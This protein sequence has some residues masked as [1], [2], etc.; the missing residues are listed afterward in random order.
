MVSNPDHPPPHSYQHTNAAP[1][2]LSLEGKKLNWSGIHNLALLLFLTNL[3]RLIVVNGKMHGFIVRYPSSFLN[4]NDF[5]AF[6]AIF[7]IFSF[8]SFVSYFLSSYGLI[9]WFSYITLLVG[10]GVIIFKNVGGTSILLSSI[11]LCCSLILFMKLFSY[12]SSKDER[13]SFGSFLRFLFLPTLCY[14]KKYPSNAGQRI[15]FRMILK[16]LIEIMGCLGMIHVLVEQYSIPTIM[17]SHHILEDLW[18]DPFSLFEHVVLLGWSSLL[19]WFLSF[20][21]I[22]HCWFNL[23][24]EILDF[25]DRQSFYKDWWNAPGINEYWQMWNGPMHQWFKRHVYHPL[26]NKYNFS[27]LQCQL[28]IF[29]ISALAHEYL[30]SVPL[31]TWEGWS[32]FA[33]FFQVPL[34]K[35][36]SVLRKKFPESK[37]LG[38]YI[39]WVIFCI[40]GQPACILL[41]YRAWYLRNK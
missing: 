14:Q 37:S 19:V 10:P 8:S 20:Y 34:I 1:S 11:M 39:F 22:F 29:V 7:A 33:M 4:F 3:L 25:G 16:Y 27:H 12:D 6:M 32:F 36:T 13:I 21:I 35:M 40:I 9:K 41:Y 2:P 5:G 18:S 15:S 24:G 28:V 17:G 26:I 38:N 30:I 23:L 31:H